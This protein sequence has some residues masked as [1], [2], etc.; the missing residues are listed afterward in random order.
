MNPEVALKIRREVGRLF[1]YWARSTE[2][3]DIIGFGSTIATD[4]LG[5]FC[6]CIH[7]LLSACQSQFA[8]VGFVV[9]W[10]GAEVIDFW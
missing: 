5:V 1:I 7:L 3:P 2:G 4:K 6:K 9:V 8:H 10:I